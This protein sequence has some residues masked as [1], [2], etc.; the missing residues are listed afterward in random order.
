M[1]T[2]NEIL[3]D[4]RLKNIV[5]YSTSIIVDDHYIYSV[6]KSCLILSGSVLAT[7]G[8]ISDYISAIVLYMA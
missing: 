8:K 3:I 4:S 2:I 7:R 5:S 1:P 6:E